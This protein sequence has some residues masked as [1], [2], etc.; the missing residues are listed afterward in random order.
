MFLFYQQFFAV[1]FIA[2]GQFTERYSG[3][4]NEFVWILF[5]VFI[6]CSS[7]CVC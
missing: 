5:L 2:P 6:S 3:Q 1:Q 7:F 4:A